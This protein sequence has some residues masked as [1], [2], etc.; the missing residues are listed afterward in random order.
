MDITYFSRYGREGPSS[1]YRVYQFLPRF[2]QAGL[3]VKIE[4]LFD[5]R[6][7]EILRTT[8]GWKRTLEKG[9]YAVSRLLERRRQLAHADTNNI[10]IEH[11]LFPYLPVS[12]EKNWLPDRYLLEFDDAIYLKHPR[13][14]PHLLG[15][16]QAAI[17]GN[18]W[19]A[20]YAGRYQAN[21]HIV[22][23][24]ID[25][26]RYVVPEPAAGRE[27]V[28][29]GWS[30]LEYNFKYLKMLAPVFEQLVKRYDNHLEIVVLSGSPPPPDIIGFPHRFET[31][32]AA[33][34]TE[35]IASF[36]IGVMPLEM[37][38]WCSGKCGMKLLQF[39]A[40]GVPAVAT[41]VGVN[42]EIVEPAANGFLA[43]SER[44]WLDHLSELIEEP[45]LR[46]KMGARARQT[47]ENRYSVKAW[48]PRLFDIYMRYFA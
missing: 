16:A 40:L 9:R 2:Q 46:R 8:S 1:R 44:D 35:Q 32:D 26:D 31:W 12:V 27:R 19:L 4:P 10:V 22:P 30:G 24:V 6:Y 21:V 48:F 42:A 37:D 28:R 3:S 33:R 29:I 17:V 39:F 20:E 14:M 11:Q 41:P 38:E 5:D 36:D 15:R 45:A 23:T 34:E 43:V 47:V 7:L 25:T 13:K 18:R